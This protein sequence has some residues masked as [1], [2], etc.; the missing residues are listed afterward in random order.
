MHH[1]IIRSLKD[2][3]IAISELKNEYPS[4]FKNISDEVILAGNAKTAYDDLATSLVKVA[5]ARA[6]EDKLV[7]NSKKALEIES[8]LKDKEQKYNETRVKLA[9]ALKDGISGG[10]YD[11]RFMASWKH[12]SS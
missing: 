7:E 8:D 2:R 6:I 11:W 1:R 3:K 12:S 4:Y 10:P 9:K 5:Q